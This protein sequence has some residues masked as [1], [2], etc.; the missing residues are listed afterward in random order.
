[1]KDLPTRL[2]EAS[3]LKIFGYLLLNLDSTFQCLGEGLLMKPKKRMRVRT[4]VIIIVSIVAV[5]G[6]RCGGCGHITIGIERRPGFDR[7]VIRK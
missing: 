7:I 4:L 6:H 5:F 1:M 3:S 2:V